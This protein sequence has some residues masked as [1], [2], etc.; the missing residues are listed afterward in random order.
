M[1]LGARP[2]EIVKMMLRQAL[3]IIAL[4]IVIGIVLA[5]ATSQLMND[6]L[7][8]VRPLDPLTYGSASSFLVLIAL[9]ASYVPA[10]R[11]MKLDPLVA[12]RYE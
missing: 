1:A 7:V 2:P 3:V 11:A 5:A 9:A 10:R 4:G 6:L 12:L 8:S